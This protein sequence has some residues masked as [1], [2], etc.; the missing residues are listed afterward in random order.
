MTWLLIAAFAATIP[1][2]NWMIGNVGTT[3]TPDGLCLIPVW[4]G[5]MAPSGVLA[6]GAALVL[7]D[8]VQRRAGSVWA[9]VAVMTGTL[10]SF[11]VAPPALAVAS[12]S[13]FLLSELA[14]FAVF[15]PLYRRRLALAVAASGVAGAIV[16]SALFLWLAFGDLAHLQGQVIGKLYATVLFASWL[17]MRRRP[18]RGASAG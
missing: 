5:V 2:A 17:W 8:L 16:D 4:P 14:D 18:F 10:L 15:T 3:C 11:W 7:R 6:I 13:A 9:L 12:A 1:A